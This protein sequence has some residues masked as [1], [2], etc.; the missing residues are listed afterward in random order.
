MKNKGYPIFGILLSLISLILLF[1]GAISSITLLIISLVGL[2]IGI[3]TL[4]C[5]STV[6][7]KW[8]CDECGEVFEI[9][10]KQNIFGV[11]SGLNYKSLYCPKCHKKT[12]CK[13]IQK[14]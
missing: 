7:Y 8:I 11:N 14:Q 10:L 4:M 1:I 13:G 2:L 6:S 5:W 12:M 9:T 3:Y